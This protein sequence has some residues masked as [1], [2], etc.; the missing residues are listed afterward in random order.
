MTENLIRIT[1]KSLLHLI[2]PN[3]NTAT[4]KEEKGATRK[5]RRDFKWSVTMMSRRKR[6]Q[7]KWWKAY[8]FLPARS[9]H[10]I[11]RRDAFSK[12]CRDARASQH[13]F[14]CSCL[15][16]HAVMLLHNCRAR[17]GAAVLFIWSYTWENM[18]L[19]FMEPNQILTLPPK[20]TGLPLPSWIYSAC[21]WR[22]ERWDEVMWSPRSRWEAF[23]FQSIEQSG[24]TGEMGSGQFVIN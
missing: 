5:E 8:F 12:Q 6:K 24:P 22:A 15:T 9:L 1:L 10:L 23:T 21:G 20:K 16:A 11:S 2:K 19:Y 17:G 14:T 3:T 7:N 18:S 13:N 4:D